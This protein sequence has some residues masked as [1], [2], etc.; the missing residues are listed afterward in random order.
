MNSTS[1]IRS[2]SNISSSHNNL[3]ILLCSATCMII[4]HFYKKWLKRKYKKFKNSKVFSVK[5]FLSQK[6]DLMGKEVIVLGKYKK[7]IKYSNMYSFQLYNHKKSKVFNFCN[8]NMKSLSISPDYFFNLNPRRGSID[9]SLINFSYIFDVFSLFLSYKFTQSISSSLIIHSNIKEMQDEYFLDDDI[10]GV[11]GTVIKSMDEN[12]SVKPDFVF[13]G[14]YMVTKNLLKTLISYLDNCFKIST[15]SLICQGLVSILDYFSKNVLPFWLSYKSKYVNGAR[16]NCSKCQI[17]VAN[18]VLNDCNH[19]NL[20]YKCFQEMDEKCM[21]CT[22]KI[23]DY[24]L[25]CG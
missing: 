21:I 3:F 15:I 12:Y 24:Y 18:V 6:Y 7:D 11:Y 23:N 5:E 20:C 19:F 1:Q 8:Y 2:G 14:N 10:V 13:Q 16:V 22:A 17:N 4:T 25:L 9:K